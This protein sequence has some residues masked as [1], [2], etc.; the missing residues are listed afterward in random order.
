MI[1][2]MQLALMSNNRPGWKKNLRGTN[3]VAYFVNDEEIS[4]YN[5]DARGQCYKTF[6]DRKLQIFLIS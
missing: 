3:A 1:Q 5:L 4:K 2:G 6:Y